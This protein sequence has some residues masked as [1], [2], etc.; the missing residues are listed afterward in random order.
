M[1]EITIAP[2]NTEQADEASKQ[3]VATLTE[4]R[5]ITIKSQDGYD[6]ASEVLKTIKGKIKLLDTLRKGITKPLDEAKQK[7]MDLFRT[8]L[9]HYEEAETVLKKGMLTY[10]EEQEALRRKEQ[11]RLERIAAEER[12]KKAEQEAEWRRKEEE[13][14]K[15]AEKLAREAAREKDAK[16]K[17]EKEALAAK[18]KAEADKAA[19]KADERAFEQQNII[20]PTAAPKVEAVAGVSYRDQWTAEVTDFEKLP[21]DYKLPDMSKLNKVAQATKG[22]LNIPGVKWNKEKIISSKSA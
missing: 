20:A 12:R 3:A 7:V 4:V 13:K 10:S 15:E 14:R 17:A 1:K 21:N 19:S 16:V 8:P 9:E 18:A 2:I 11:E 22:T 5:S 6:K